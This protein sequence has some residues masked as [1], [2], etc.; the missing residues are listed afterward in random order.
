MINI[1]IFLFCKNIYKYIKTNEKWFLPVNQN[2]KVLIQKVI[3]YNK[4]KKY[5]NQI[6]NKHK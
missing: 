6:F 1:Y 3:M 4:N 2:K 5:N